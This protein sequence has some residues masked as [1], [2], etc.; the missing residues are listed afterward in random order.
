MFDITIKDVTFAYG[1]NQVLN[2][3][4]LEIAAGDFVAMVG[5]NGAGKSTLLKM[6]AGLV[7]PDGG[8]VRVA[9]K[10]IVA[11]CIAGKIGYV[12]QHYANN[13]AGFPA[14]VEEIVALGLN[15]DG[16]KKVNRDGARHIVTHM[17][18]LVGMEELRRRLVGE[19]SGGQQQRVMVARALAANPGVLLLD[20]PTSGVDYDTGTKIY[21]LLGELNRNLGITIVAVS[22]DIEKVVRVA[23]KVACINNGICF[24]GDSSEFRKNHAS[25]PHFFSYQVK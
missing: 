15:S 25:E 11:A 2:N 13:T 1:A 6:I 5:P 18:K 19:L 4:S 16:T 21:G 8:I 22:H 3:L 14:T 20:E 17:L 24:Y 9:G 12:P 23:S 7:R 10:E